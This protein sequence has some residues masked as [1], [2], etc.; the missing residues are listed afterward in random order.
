MTSVNVAKTI[1]PNFDFYE[2]V[3]YAFADTAQNVTYRNYTLANQVSNTSIPFS[4]STPGLTSNVLSRL[5]FKSFK[6]RFSY[7]IVAPAGV[8]SHQI[9]NIC[10]RRL[11]LANIITNESVTINNFTNTINLQQ[12]ADTLTRYAKFDTYN[13]V[14]FDS[15]TQP[16]TT[17]RYDE[18]S[19]LALNSPFNQ[20]PG[21][22]N[23][24][25]TRGT[26][27]IRIIS[28]P[29]GDG[30]TAQTV[31]FEYTFYE[32]VMVSPF[33]Y[34]LEKQKDLAWIQTLQMNWT[35]GNITRALS[36]VDDTV[37]LSRGFG[38]VQ[39]LTG[40]II[41]GDV[42]LKWQT[43]PAGLDIPRSI[44][45]D[46]NRID[47]YPTSINQTIPTD[48]TADVN[49]NTVKFTNVPSHVY[50]AIKK[51]DNRKTANDADAYQP[52]TR[53]VV[54]YGNRE[55]QLSNARP[56][57]IYRIMKEN[58]L[59]STNIAQSMVLDET[60]YSVQITDNA[61]AF[62]YRFASVPT[63]LQYPKDFV[64]TDAG[65][66]PP[67]GASYD[68]AFNL[69]VTFRNV[70]GQTMTSGDY[71]LMVIAVTPLA[72][73]LAKDEITNVNQLVTYQEAE[74]MR[75]TNMFSDDLEGSGLMGG[76]MLGGA[77][78]GGS[79]WGKV[80]NFAK[81]AT[82]KIKGFEEGAMRQIKR[83]TPEILGTVGTLAPEFLPEATALT[84]FAQQYGSGMLSAA[85]KK[86]LMQEAQK[87]RGG[88]RFIR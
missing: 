46:Y 41:D 63:L 28:N 3:V 1:P 74:G 15:I 61:G 17:Q 65:E 51:R 70:S 31:E 39:N 81:K 79:W 73:T 66:S 2:S 10:P 56:I 77:M 33:Q 13:E 84:A 20:A 45:Y 55:N 78:L 69:Q 42:Y 26:Y 9:S 29:L 67:P 82:K 80:K 83:Y 54:G 4:V 86:K 62:K 32:P 11:P 43:M 24:D 34:G 75:P 88:Q 53:I 6:I 40:D 14:L 8:A 71:E 87:R 27:P 22:I 37:L 25:M 57:D 85:Q 12:V 5:A 47:V 7:D 58:G 38:A 59:K 72:F 18:F 48:T 50:F 60:G 35:I 49:F 23:E 52:S 21:C 30:L 16:D 44:V 68:S 64:I 36:I 76:A 19:V